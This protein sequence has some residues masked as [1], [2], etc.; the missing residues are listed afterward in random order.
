MKSIFLVPLFVLIAAGAYA[1][2]CNCKTS[3]EWV[4]KTFEENDAGYAHILKQKGQDAYNMHNQLTLDRVKNTTNLDSCIG[5]LQDWVR[6]F[7][8]DHFRF[9]KTASAPAPPEFKIIH[10]SKFSAA[11]FKQYL[12]KSTDSI[13]GIWESPDYTI[14]VRKQNNSYTGTVITATAAS[15]KPGDLKFD[16]SADLKTGTR[17][18]YGN[19]SSAAIAIKKIQFVGKGKTVLQ[20]DNFYLKRPLAD[21]A[22]NE[23]YRLK[24][25]P[26]PFGYKRDSN[27]V[28]IHINSFNYESKGAI[29]SV[30]KSLHAAIITTPNLIIDLRDCQGGSD[31]SFSNLVPYLYTNPI[32]SVMAE[33]YSTPM[34]NQMWKDIA[35]REGLDPEEKKTYLDIADLMNSKLGQFVNIFG[36]DVNVL[37]LNKVLPYPQNIGIIIHENNFS[38]TEEFILKAKQ[39][40]KVK[41]FG[42]KTGGALDVS[43]MIE[44]K[45]PAGN[46]IFEYCISRS[47]RIPEFPVDDMGLHPDFYLDRTIPETEWVDFTTSILNAK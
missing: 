46:F 9:T 45:D 43:N 14:A 29:D 5:Y 33:F 34:N 25:S 22:T 12:D 16:M 13:E 6:F 28:Y 39:S 10:D 8:T 23:Y 7:R 15:W 40:K 35:N 21:V 2:Q 42:R 3:F 11:Q 37:T 4:R 26:Q 41:F 20:L 47:L 17:Y 32:R 31:A 36:K 24:T 44:A 18:V 38:T 19:K 30:L 1:Q 27:T